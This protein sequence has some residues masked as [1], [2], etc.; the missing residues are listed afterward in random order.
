LHVLRNLIARCW[1]FWD[2]KNAALD[3]LE[4]QADRQKF[5]SYDVA[6]CSK[7]LAPS[8]V[9]LGQ[10]HSGSTTLAMQLD[11]HPELSYG[12][13]KEHHWGEQLFSGQGY[14]KEYLEQYDVPCGTRVSMDF[15]P[16]EYLDGHHGSH[17]NNFYKV[18]H[19]LPWVRRHNESA[20][21]SP[22]ILRNVLGNETK[23]VIMLRDPVDFLD[24]L[25]YWWRNHVRMAEGDCY[26]NGVE[27]WLQV[28]PRRNVFFI[29][30]EDYFHNAQATLSELFKFLGV[31]AWQYP[32]DIP[33]SGRRRQAHRITDESR[34][35][36]HT[37]PEHV[38]C[39][40]R[41]ENLT[42]LRFEWPG[43]AS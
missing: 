19:F 13:V 31:K 22:H 3:I 6:S 7:R 36:Y 1:E 35:D 26:A 25:P 18:N 38:A 12:R 34:R 9:Y 33:S 15:S 37:R 23:L 8:M 20:M 2:L 11:A 32:G 21:V 4:M 42:G 24:S 28:F 5:G 39:R 14:E 43:A 30:A 10:G 17:W 41:L 16:G 40:K 27:K 29:R